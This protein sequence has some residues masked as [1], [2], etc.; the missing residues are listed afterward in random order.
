LEVETT[1]AGEFASAMQE[2]SAEAE[3]KL[4]DDSGAKDGTNAA[5]ATLLAQIAREFYGLNSRI[6]DMEAMLAR[7]LEEMVNPRPITDIFDLARQFKKIDAQLDAIR[8]AEGVNQR[9]FDSMHRELKE[10]RDNFL[11]ESLQKP[12]IRDLIV[13]FDDLT[14]LSGQLKSAGKT[15]AKRGP[16]KHSAENLE[17]TIHGLVEILHRLEVTEIASKDVVDLALHKVVSYE[18]ADFAEE[19]GHIVMRL[20]RGFLWRDKVLRPE[21]VIAKRY[22]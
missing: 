7:R 20:K 4:P 13:L 22:N 9:L 2:L 1:I 17:N 19:D 21:E 12:F 14:A 10:Y 16:L 6:Q 18:P 11:H 8:S 15:D 5:V 3:K